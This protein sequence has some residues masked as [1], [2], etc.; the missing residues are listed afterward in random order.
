LTIAPWGDV[1]FCEDGIHPRIFGISPAGD[2][3]QISENIGYLSEFAGLC[4]SPSG[5]TLFVNIQVPGIT[6]A[7]TGDWS[8][9]K[10]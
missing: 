7:I 2:F 5:N 10:T 9:L 4:F 6:L 3:Y 1:V 8:Q